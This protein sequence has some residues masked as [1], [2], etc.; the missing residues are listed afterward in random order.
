MERSSLKKDHAVN[1]SLDQHQG[2]QYRRLSESTQDDP[3][4]VHVVQRSVQICAGDI[5]GVPDVGR[6]REQRHTPAAQVH[7]L[8][9]RQSGGGQGRDDSPLGQGVLPVPA[10]PADHE[11]SPEDQAGGDQSRHDPSS[12]AVL[13]VVASCSGDV[14]RT[15][16]SSSSFQ[17]SS[18]HDERRST[19]IPEPIGGS[20]PVSQE[21]SNFLSNHLAPRTSASYKSNFGKFEHFCSSLGAD[22]TSCPPEVIAAFVQH[23][24]DSGASY[25]SVNS[26]RSAISKYH[27]G[28]NGVPAGQHSLVC[29][30]VRAVFRLRPPIPKYIH[31]FDVV[32]VFD[33]VKKLPQNSDLSLKLLTYKALFLL[34]VSSLSRVSSVAQL[35]P[36]L[37]VY[38]VSAEFYIILS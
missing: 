7:V 27:I 10:R 12:V 19:S 36:H 28:I 15:S 1:P 29:Q 21:L 33:Y 25:S 14:S 34:I 5:G 3:V 17:G 18:N 35:G 32:Q 13:S 11:V 6:V 20:A 4:G 26:A 30:A 38:K 31:T 23:L 37:I 24:F 2:Q 9:P 8:V 16:T 22:P